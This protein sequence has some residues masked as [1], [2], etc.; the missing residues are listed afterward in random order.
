MESKREYMYNP[1]VCPYCGSYRDWEI[2]DRDR[3]DATIDERVDCMA[4]GHT[5]ISTYLL[6]SVYWMDEDERTNIDDPKEEV[7]DE[8][9]N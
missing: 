8:S 3:Y 7:K 9:T 1:Y 6:V 2:T 4:C 5:W